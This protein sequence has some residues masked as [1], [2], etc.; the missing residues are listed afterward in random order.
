MKME[1]EYGALHRRLT[2]QIHS[3]P[4]AGPAEKQLRSDYLRLMEQWR[5]QGAQTPRPLC[6]ERLRHFRRLAG[7][8]AALAAELPA[9][10]SVHTEEEVGLGC[11]DL[12]AP[13]LFLDESCSEQARKTFR[14]LCS[15]AAS[16]SLDAS[17]GTLR[18]RAVFRLYE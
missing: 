17:E 1:K 2:Q 6:P 18:L 13:A 15:E 14:R 7:Q 8:A 4:E 10:L 3:A 5:K 9:D 16:I 12:I 11:I